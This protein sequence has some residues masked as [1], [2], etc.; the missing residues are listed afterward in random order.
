MKLRIAGMM[1][2]A[3]VLALGSAWASA[4]TTPR[5]SPLAGPTQ[6]LADARAN[7]IKA[8]AAVDVIR[9]KLMPSFETKPDFKAA[10]DAI[11]AAHAEMDAATRHLTATLQSSPEYKAQIAKREKAQLV[12][13]GGLKTGPSSDDNA[14]KVT[15]DDLGDA[16]K[17][18]IEAVYA[19]KK[20]E[21]DAQE[22]DTRYVAARLKY[23]EAEE[24]W[25][26]LQ[27]QVDD[28][29]KLDPGY[30]A[31]QQG[32]Q[33]AEEALKQAQDQYNG[34]VKAQQNSHP[35]PAPRR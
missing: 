28:A 26:N 16:H 17:D 29:V 4:A 15:A 2:L 1:A 9:K 20:M 13:D 34:A 11:E 35:A 21:K 18:R 8:K 31:A 22:N 12:I 25:E 7:L 10:K 33:K 19:I 3:A 5:T 6:A 27:G 30:P 32:V 14:V 24:Q 23:K